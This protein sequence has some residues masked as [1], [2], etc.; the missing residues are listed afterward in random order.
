MKS[1]IRSAFA[2]VVLSCAPS[3]PATQQT[4]VQIQQVEVVVTAEAPPV[5]GEV[6]VLLIGKPDEDSLDLVTG[7]E[8]PGVQNLETMFEAA[9]PSIDIQI[10][11]IPWGSG[12]TGYGPK[13]ES[14]IQAQEACVYMMQGASQYGRRGYLEW[15]F[16]AIAHAF[17][18][19]WGQVN[20]DGTWTINWDTPEYLQALE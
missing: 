12:A 17:G 13:T 3:A 8:I 14:M 16:Q 10:T 11:N 18:A 6:K 1:Q 5:S 20:D 7:K 4:V 9:Y 19:T 2:W 15:Q